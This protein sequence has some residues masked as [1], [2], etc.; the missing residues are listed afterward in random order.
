[1]RLFLASLLALALLAL[2]FPVLCMQGESDPGSCSSISGIRLP[3]TAEHAEWW[4]LVVLLV[5]VA[6]FVLVLRM[7]RR[8]DDE[9]A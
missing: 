6:S 3:G 7:G 2:F 4:Q 5:V 8:R 1:M 9:H